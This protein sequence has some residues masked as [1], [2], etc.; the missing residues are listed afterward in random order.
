MERALSGRL[1]ERALSG[2]LV[3]PALSERPM[4][5]TLSGCLVERAP[6][7]HVLKQPMALTDEICLSTY[8]SIVD[9]VVMG[10]PGQQD[11]DH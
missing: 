3:E 8:Y 11:W 1:V 7:V 9:E 6:S 10:F 4:E 2:H 5:R